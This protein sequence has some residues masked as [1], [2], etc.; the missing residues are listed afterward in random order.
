MGRRA[1]ENFNPLPGPGDGDFVPA[2]HTCPV[3]Q[4]PSH[5]TVRHHPRKV[6]GQ[7]H[8]LQMRHFI[9]TIY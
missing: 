2:P 4:R 9:V 5:G 6:K 3:C 1:A 8:A 7:G